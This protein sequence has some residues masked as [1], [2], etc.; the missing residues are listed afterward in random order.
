[1]GTFPTNGYAPDL[2]ALCARVPCPGDLDVGPPANP[3][4]R[5]RI[6]E[7]CILTIYLMLCREI[8]RIGSRPVLRECG[9]N[10]FLRCARFR[11]FIVI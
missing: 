4:S 9:A 7:N 11:L 5:L 10:F 1:M 2:E 3:L 8:V 6:V